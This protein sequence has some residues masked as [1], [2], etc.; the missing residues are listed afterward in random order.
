MNL[1]YKQLEPF[2]SD[3]NLNPLETVMVQTNYD[4]VNNLKNDIESDIKWF[5][6]VK[7]K[8]QDSGNFIDNV[9]VYGFDDL[10]D[11]KIEARVLDIAKQNKDLLTI[12][13]DAELKPLKKT[14]PKNAVRAKYQLEF[15]KLDPKPKA[16]ALA[17][18][19]NDEKKERGRQY[20]AEFK[21]LDTEYQQTETYKKNLDALDENALSLEEKEMNNILAKF[22]KVKTNILTTLDYITPI[23]TVAVAPTP[24]INVVA[25]APQPLVASKPQKIYKTEDSFKNMFKTTVA[26]YLANPGNY[27]IF[28]EPKDHHMI[29]KSRFK[30]YSAM[31]KPEKLAFFP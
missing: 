23:T 18:L 4:A 8:L 14:A 7:A 10:D 6:D 16:K 13:R 5:V 26:D 3:P 20:T 15:D 24:T 30:A 25:N 31:T 22:E 2:F 17:T 28:K 19:F 12:A 1:E 21:T 29:I 27:Q 9:L 11:A